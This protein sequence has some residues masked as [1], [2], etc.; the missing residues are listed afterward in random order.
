ML[1]IGDAGST[2]KP[3]VGTGTGVGTCGELVQGFTSG[4]QPFHVTCPIEKSS[5]VSVTLSPAREFRVLR[6][7]EQLDK[8]E[9]SLLRTATYLDVEPCEIRVAHW[10]D[11]ETGK[12]L[13]SSTA[14]VVAAA[15]AI[16]AALGRQLNATELASIA[17]SIE[18]SDGSMHP[19]L[20]AFDQKSGS[21]LRR[22]TWW[23]QFLIVMVVPMKVLNT[24]SVDFSG[25]PNLGVEFDEILASLDVAANER[26]PLGFAE[27]AS[28]SAT[29]NQRF[30]PNPYH[31]LLESRLEQM[32]ALGINV[33]H[34]GTAVGVLFDAEQPDA[35]RAASA[36]AVEVQSM[37]PDARVEVTLTPRWHAPE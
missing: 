6:S 37:F 10:T 19:G 5:T 15:R 28:R 25:K 34:T 29:L 27:A 8:V 35:M 16:A 36:A 12:G 30:V 33:A 24:E 26:N 9:L 7:T 32:G 23:P 3:K 21:V 2:S 14:D 22:Y 13:G 17:T 18:S 4:G 11:L 1:V 31:A 20:V